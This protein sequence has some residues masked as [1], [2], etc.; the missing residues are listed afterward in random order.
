MIQALVQL[1][2]SQNF[3]DASVLR[4][5]VQALNEFRTAVVD[6]LN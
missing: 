6:A 1:A 3:A 4:E 2:S 5:V